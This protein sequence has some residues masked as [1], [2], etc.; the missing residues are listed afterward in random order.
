M[1]AITMKMIQLYNMTQTNPQTFFAGMFAVTRQSF[2]DTEKVTLDIVKSNND[3]AI[4]VQDLSAGYR[5]NMASVFENNE[6]TP[7]VFKESFQ[8]NVFELIKRQP[9]KNPFEN[10][11]FRLTCIQKM[12]RGVDAVA[13]KIRRSNELQAAQVMQTGKA[14]FRDEEGAILFTLDYGAN[15]THFPVASKDWSDPTAD[16][17]GDLTQLAAIVRR[18]GKVTPNRLIFGG[19]AWA[20]AQANEAFMKRFDIRNAHYGEI[21]LPEMRGEGGTFHGRIS[22]GNYVYDIWTYDDFYNDP[23]TGEATE[24]MDTN[25]V[26]VMSTQSRLDALFGSVPNLGELLGISPRKELLP[27]LPARLS[28]SQTGVDMFLN[29]WTDERIENLFAGVGSR[30]IMCPTALDSFGC[31]TT[32]K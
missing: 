12:Y 6:I 28:S 16:I 15:P 30:P 19:T 27:E 2:F 25:K 11:D 24:Y 8:V 17:I 23:Q 9:G 26:I 22:L 4:A 3:I 7:P 20:N 14:T 5:N 13:R 1:N 29:V 31:I 21:R 10:Q 32:K 18:D